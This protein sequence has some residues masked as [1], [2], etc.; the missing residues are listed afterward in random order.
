MTKFYT[1]FFSVSNK[2]KSDLLI[3]NS[4]E[5]LLNQFYKQTS[6]IF[7]RTKKSPSKE[8]INKILQYAKN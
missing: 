3:F 4:E 1:I 7:D 5:K 8:V 6:R 2:N